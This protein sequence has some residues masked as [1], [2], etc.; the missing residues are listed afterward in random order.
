MM[1][2]CTCP[3]CACK[4]T[5]TCLHRGE[6]PAR[7]P[8]GELTSFCMCC[9]SN[10]TLPLDEDTGHLPEFTKEDS[11]AVIVVSSQAAIPQPAV[12]ATP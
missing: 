3:A 11:P 1:A 9:V 6:N 7:L 2:E 12:A 4:D 5:W 8:S 10:T